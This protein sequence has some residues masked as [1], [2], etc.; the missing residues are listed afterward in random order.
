VWGDNYTIETNSNYVASNGQSITNL[1]AWDGGAFQIFWP[2]LRND[3]SSYVGFRNSRYNMLVTQLDYASQNRIP[4]ILS[5]SMIPGVDYSGAIGIP[6][7]SEANMDLGAINTIVG[8][9]GSTYA[10]AAA[11]GIDK[12]AV[13]SWLYAIDSNLSGMMG[14]Y[15]FYDSARSGTEISNRFYGIDV[16][17]TI[18]GL[19]GNGP[20]DFA[21]YLSNRATIESSYHALYEQKNSDLLAAINRT[22]TVL[23]VAP[24]FPDRSLAVFS[25]IQ[26]QGHINNFSD[27]NVDLYG[28][29]GIRF[30]YG[31]LPG[32][33]EGG[34]SWILDEH[35]NAQANQL[36][37]YYSTNPTVLG[38]SPKQIRIELKYDGV[39]VCA[40]ITVNVADN[41]T[42]FSRL[43]IDLP[44]DALLSAI[45]EIDLMIDQA[46]SGDAGGDFTIHAI[47]FQHVAP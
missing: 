25:H 29:A 18:L 1:A 24:E 16:A 43:T 26:A 10:L 44:D 12:N 8:D 11:M 38:S 27:A 31:V 17:S 33:Q 47:D 21:T 13:L 4:G 42:S 40:P 35:Y 30:H 9:V 2:D 5:A 36:L 15:G 3:E 7:I 22:S 45:D 28:T 14:D 41:A 32:N 37:V 39:A 23:P 20:D 46:D 34:H 19:S 6:Q